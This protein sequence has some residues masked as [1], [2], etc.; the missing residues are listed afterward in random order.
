MGL[1]QDTRLAVQND[2]PS[3]VGSG[4]D[5][6]LRHVRTLKPDGVQL[7]V[8]ILHRLCK[9]G[10]EPVD[11]VTSC[12]RLCMP[13]CPPGGCWRPSV[14][15]C[16]LLHPGRQGIPDKQDCNT[17]RSKAAQFHPECHIYCAATGTPL[18]KSSSEAAKMDSSDEPAEAQAQLSL[19]D[20]LAP[21]PPPADVEMADQNAPAAAVQTERDPGA[22][23]SGPSTSAPPGDASEAH[24]G[25]L[26]T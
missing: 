9:L 15:H 2:T 6:L 12:V 19:P 3:V 5:E 18:E 8:T 26:R 16:R 17:E 21:P 20:A 4:L 25:G 14:C 11:A 10:G 24:T 22:G 7:I 1:P 23:G 13:L